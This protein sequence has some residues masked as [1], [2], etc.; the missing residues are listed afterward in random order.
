[1]LALLA[2]LASVVAREQRRAREA[3]L[4]LSRFDPLTGL[5]NRAYFF[6]VLD[7]ELRRSARTG[8]RFAVVMFDLD[9]LKYVNDTLGHPIGDELMRGITDAVRRNVRGTDVAARYGGDEFIVLLADTDS[10]GAFI[11][12]EKLRAD[13][14]AMAVGAADRPARTSASFGV[15]TYPDDGAT[16][17]ELIQNADDAMYQAKR[18]GKNQIVGYRTRT[19]RVATQF[20]PRGGDDADE[21]FDG[22]EPDR[23]PARIGAFGAAANE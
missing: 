7:R 9:A 3:A 14:A 2:Y 5:Y 1:M 18:N 11:V 15:V 17:E 22:S 21:R 16:I 6:S 13:I 10:Q 20:R 4:S 23:R 12:A 19:E 8:S